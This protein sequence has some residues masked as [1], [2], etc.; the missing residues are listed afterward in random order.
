MLGNR[1]AL[2]HNGD[3]DGKTRH[4]KYGFEFYQYWVHEG[5]DQWDIGRDMCNA[6]VLFND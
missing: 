3:W 2:Y 5:R 1:L 6:L 4:E